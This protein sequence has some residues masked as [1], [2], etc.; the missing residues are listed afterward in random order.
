MIPLFDLSRVVS[1]YKSELE[2]SISDCIST[3]RFI[4]GPSVLEFEN[5]LKKYL[6]SKNVMGVSSG[7]DA[8]LTIFMS[9]G[10]SPGD[11]VLVTPFTFVASATSIARAGLSPV[12]VDLGEDSFHPTIEQYEKNITSKT[13]A[14]L[15]VHLFGEPNDLLELRKFCDSKNLLLIEDCAQSLGST[16][17]SK[18]VGTY[19]DAAA[20]SFFP[21]KNLGCFGDGG[22]ICTDNEDIFETAKIVKSHGAKEKYNTIM[23]GGN[24][25]LDT[26]QA[27]I[28]NI[29]LPQL[30]CW[31]EKRTQ[32][33]KY[34]TDNL[35]HLDNL[36]L[37]KNT[38][39]H[40]WNQY[41]LRLENRD[42]LKKYLDNKKIGN[43]V[44]Y[45]IPLHRQRLFYKSETLPNTEKRC[46]EVLSIP[47]YPGL[48][49]KERSLVVESI[50]EFME[51]K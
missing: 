42:D 5:N 41:T 47:I 25:R 17:N 2:K 3:A 30:E 27:G 16:W 44:Y 34:Y 37:P 36:T 46:S 51:K 6:G 31:I 15:C 28:L 21:A 48:T 50:L 35:S 26:I 32:N 23:M 14:I 8:L 10:L 9:L 24:F 22:A 18:K 13:K 12:L 45:P 40:S 11:E 29:L 39:G 49:E 38:P 7:T 43:A 33:A 1:P 20:F 4:N 19:G